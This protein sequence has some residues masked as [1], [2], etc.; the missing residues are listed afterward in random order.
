MASAA[1]RCCGSDGA[2]AARA[3]NRHQVHA[4]DAVIEPPQLE[5]ILR[6]ITLVG[7]HTGEAV[8][9]EGSS[10]GRR[11]EHLLVTGQGSNSHRIEESMR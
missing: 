3:R 4:A 8:Q 7:W 9:R 6:G 5:L 10:G 2:A 11:D 1:W